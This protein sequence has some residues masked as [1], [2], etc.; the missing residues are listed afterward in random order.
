MDGRGWVVVTDP[1]IT[2]DADLRDPQVALFRAVVTCID[3][4]IVRAID[5]ASLIVWLAVEW[6]SRGHG[7]R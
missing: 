6:G 7:I 2:I 4:F 5:I 1:S 3:M